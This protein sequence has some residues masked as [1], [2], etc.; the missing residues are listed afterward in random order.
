MPGRAALTRF[1]TNYRLR[2][3]CY[4]FLRRP[5]SRP[6]L[7]RGR[8]NRLGQHFYRAGPGHVIAAEGVDR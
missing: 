7:R 6:H 8:G 3:G 5:L 2:P 4:N 1:S